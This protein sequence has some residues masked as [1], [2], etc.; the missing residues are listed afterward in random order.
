MKPSHSLLIYYL[1]VLPKINKNKVFGDFPD[2]KAFV[3]YENKMLKKW[4]KRHFSKG[5]IHGFEFFPSFYLIGKQALKRSLAIF[6][7]GKSVSRL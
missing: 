4:K 7:I 3:D 6:W 2:K 1:N 5:V